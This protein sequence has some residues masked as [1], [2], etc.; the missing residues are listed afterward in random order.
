MPQR[1]EQL[2]NLLV[3]ILASVAMA[4][5]RQVVGVIANDTFVKARRRVRARLRRHR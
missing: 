1:V 2:L 5:L 3:P 4:V